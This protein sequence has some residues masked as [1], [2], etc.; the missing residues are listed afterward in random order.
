MT[1]SWQLYGRTE[2]AWTVMLED[3]EQA[4]TSIDLEQYIFLDDAIGRKFID[5]FARKAKEGVRVRVLV[6]SAG[7][8][9]VFTSK[10]AKELRAKGIEFL[11]FNPFPTARLGHFFSWFLRDHRKMLIVDDRIAHTGG[12]CVD[13]K[14][15][16]WR[17][18]L[19]R[20]EGPLVKLMADAFERMWKG[21]LWRQ[22]FHFRAKR[23]QTLPD[24]FGFYT[25][26]PHFGQRYFYWALIDAIRGARKYIYLTSPYFIPDRR[27][28][29]ALRLA[30]QR[31]VDVRILTVQKSDHNFIDFASSY[32]ISPALHRGIRWFRYTASMM[33]AKSAVIDDR[34]ATVGSSNV[35]NWSFVYN[36]E[37]NVVSTNRKFIEEVKSMFLADLP[38]S[39]EMDAESWSRRPWYRKLM[40]RLVRPIHRF[41]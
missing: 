13:Q 40:E 36:Y 38:N 25:N 17:D 18:T 8:F 3:C 7:S 6:D 4:V 15:T 21:S 27:I 23:P 16:S 35:D 32:Y 19:F 2:D 26:S 30:A 1:T 33:H 31:G 29:R 39:R 22:F 11:F 37:A 14:M 34:W 28:F 24:G 5:L 9:S 41:M 10:F 12:V 20:V